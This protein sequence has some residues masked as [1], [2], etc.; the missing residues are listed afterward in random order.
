MRSLPVTVLIAAKNEAANLPRCLAA[1][2]RFAR[3]VVVDSHSQDAMATLAERFG[4]EVVQFTYAGGY[5]KKRQ[6]ALDALAID[7]PWTLLLD[8]DEIAPAALVDEIAHVVEH[9]GPCNAYL[10]VK[11]FHFLGRRFRFGGFSHAAVALFRTGAARFE[12]LIDDAPDAL[13]MEVHERLIVD[14][15]VGRLHTPLVHEDVKGLEAYLDK[16]NKYSTWEARVRRKFLTTGRWGEDAITPRLTG[17]AQ[18]Q[19]RFLKQLAMRMP[20]EP[21]LWLTYHLVLRGGFLE[22]RRG[23]IASRIR[24]QYIADVRAKLFELNQRVAI[25][26]TPACSP[27]MECDAPLKSPQLSLGER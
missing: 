14:E 23:W 2:A 12:R 6:W 3:V 18:Q 25:I 4:A 1:L 20:F 5:P 16:H 9:S 8:A 11:G 24:A 19:R 27:P 17:D 10:I 26:A 22:G 7:T 13:D 21:W 15:P